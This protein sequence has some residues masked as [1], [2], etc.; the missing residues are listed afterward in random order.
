NCEFMSVRSK[1]YPGV[2]IQHKCSRFM[3]IS[4]LWSRGICI[5]H[6]KVANEGFRVIS[7]SGLPSRTGPARQ[8]GPTC[9][10]AACHG[11]QIVSDRLISTL[12]ASTSAFF[13]CLLCSL[14]A[15]AQQ[16]FQGQQPFAGQQ[17]NFGQQPFMAQ[18]PYYN[19]PN[20][21]SQQMVPGQNPIMGQPPY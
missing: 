2:T 18:Q 7:R 15:S 11:G 3:T 17:P 12:F 8:A 21:Q 1:V 6:G 10:I 19:Q 14:P 20:Y 13:A 4:G 16:Y 5:L 9:P